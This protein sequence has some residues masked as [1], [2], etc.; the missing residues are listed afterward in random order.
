MQA[1]KKNLGSTLAAERSPMK[2]TEAQK[3][4]FG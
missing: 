2:E 1:W 4:Q 3:S